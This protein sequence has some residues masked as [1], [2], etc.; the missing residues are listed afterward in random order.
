MPNDDQ[1]TDNIAPVA[2]NTPG[3]TI[4][5]GVVFPAG[6]ESSPLEP[7][8]EAT[9]FEPVTPPA[10]PISYAPTA[11]VIVPLTDASKVVVP[12]PLPPSPMSPAPAELIAP[13]ASA[14]EVAAIPEVT[15]LPEEVAGTLPALE[16]TASETDYSHKGLWWYLALAAIIVALVATAVIFKLWLGIGVFL[17]MGLT[18]GVYAQRGP[19][20]QTYRLDDQGLTVEGKLYTFDKFKTF[21]VISDVSWHTIDLE[22]TAR[23]MPRLNI[24]YNDADFGAIVDRL[25]DNLPRQDRSPEAIER[26]TRWLRF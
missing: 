14:P 22:S 6:S 12:E 17:A 11:D 9:T 19:H 8:V 13:P 23:F 20:T 3:A 25:A 4:L 18:I 16:W 24:L 21:G 10:P 7:P 5:P 15:A 26:L 2:I 1:L